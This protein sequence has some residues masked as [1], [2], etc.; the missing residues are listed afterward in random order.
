[1]TS[2][3]I[4]RCLAVLDSGSQRRD[5]FM[6]VGADETAST[7]FLACYAR[8]DVQLAAYAALE[9]TLAWFLRTTA[10]GTASS[11]DRRSLAAGVGWTAARV[12][13]GSPTP[14][15]QE[16]A[17]VGAAFAVVLLGTSDTAPSGVHLFE[18]NLRRIIDAHVA[19]GTVPVLSTIPPRGDSAAADA[20]VP[21]MN[22][23]IRALA[24]ARQVP[25]VD[26]W[27]VLSALPNRG[28]TGDGI[29]LSVHRTGT[30]ARPCRLD[31]DGLAFGMNQRNRLTL[32]ALDRIRRFVLVGEAPEAAPPG[33]SGQGTWDDPLVVDGLPFVDDGDTRTGVSVVSRYGSFP[34]DEGGPEVVYRIDLA[35]P[36]KIR[37]R[38]FVDDGVD[39]DLHWLDAPDPARTVARADKTLDVLAPAGTFYLSADTFV[40]SGQPR[41][42]PYRLTVLAI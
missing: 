36:A 4:A 25:Y 1:M 28:L 26:L 6:K 21:E 7:N 30:Q 40:A 13:E 39:V 17:A 10:A 16:T 20:T 27:Q 11:F 41:P 42:G 34:Q 22:A 38:V 23:V 2:A 32:E 14:L 35:A 9:P 24:Q 33:L 18:R 8:S 3:V 31:T 37:A 15:A 29:H 12:L 19:S 5:V